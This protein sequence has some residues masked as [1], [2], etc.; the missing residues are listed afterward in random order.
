MNPMRELSPDPRQDLDARNRRVARILLTV[1][2][3]LAVLALLAGV[4]W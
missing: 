1:M 3:V 2:A 4:R